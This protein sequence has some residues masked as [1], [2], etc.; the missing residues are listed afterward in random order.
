MKGVYTGK[1]EKVFVTNQGCCQ[2]KTRT[3]AWSV[4][5]PI[6]EGIESKS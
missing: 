4:K 1:G 3:Y 5:K 6:V 2:A